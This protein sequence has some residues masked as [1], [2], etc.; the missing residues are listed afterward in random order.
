MPLTES[1]YRER[2]KNYDIVYRT[3]HAEVLKVRRLAWYAE[4]KKEI[5]ELRAAWRA[6]NRPR[7]RDAVNSYQRKWYRK[8]KDSGKESC[9]T[10]LPNRIRQNLGGRIRTM[11]RT[12]KA[13]KIESTMA[14][15]GCSI[16]FLKEYIQARFLPGMTWDN[17]GR[18]EGKWNI[19]HRIPCSAFD[20]SDGNDQRAAFHYSNLQPLWSKDNLKKHASLPEPHQAELI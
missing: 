19:D 4:N 12:A 2:K 18:G 3:R 8:V 6:K 13:R 14:L 11:I 10:R 9:Y 15:V 5:N 7:N 20:M 16:P 1:Q 17:H